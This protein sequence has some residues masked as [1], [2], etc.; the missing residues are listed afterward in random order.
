MAKV[1]GT[2]MRAGTILAALADAGVPTVV[3]TA[4]GKLRKML[5]KDLH[6]ICFSSERA[7][8]STVEV[9]GIADVEA[10]VGRPAPNMYS[11]DLSLFVLDAGIKLLEMG[12]GELFYLSLSD[13]IQHGHAPGEPESDAFHR[14]VDERVGRLI[15]LG[16]VVGL[17][18]DH[19]MRDKA[20]A[21]G[22]PKVIY[23]EDELNARFRAGAGRVICPI[24]DP[25]VKHHGAL[26]SFVRVY[27]RNG[28]DVATVMAASAELPGISTVITAADA[29]KRF[30]LPLDREGDFVVLSDAA[31]V[32]GASVGEHN[33]SGL[34]GHRLRS[35]G[36]LGEQRVPF[37]VSEPLT[38]EYH[39]RASAGALRNF[40]IFDFVL[41]G[42]A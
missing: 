33:L 19:G 9:N 32:V 15:E 8:L 42:T 22:A 20:E 27:R 28:P 7:N 40:A 25:Y 30:D 11:G 31:T 13:F 16:A 26:G 10:F 41:N 36:G 5:G 18:A 21:D 29:A 37:L 12:K 2:L 39:Q 24:T 4:K 3:V 23:L 17:V 1:A 6:G 38:P 35:H 34:D 14:A